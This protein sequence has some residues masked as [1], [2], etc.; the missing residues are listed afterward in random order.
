MRFGF[1]CFGL[2]KVPRVALGIASM[3]ASMVSAVQ[4]GVVNLGSF[5]GEFVTVGDP[6]NRAELTNGFGAVSETF[7]IM[8]FEFTNQQYV[9]FLNSV[10]PNGNQTNGIYNASMGSDARGGISFDSG[11]ATG[12]KYAVRL[13]MHHKPVNYVSW[14]DAARVANWLHNGATS[15]SSMETGAYTL[16]NA[17]TGNAVPVNI[18][19]RF[20][21][22]SENQWYKAAYYKGGS[23]N[24]GYWP[25]ATQSLVAPFAVT[26]NTTG[27]GSAGILDNFAN[28]NDAA[29]WNGQNGNVT[30]VGTNGRPSAYGAFDMIGNVREWNDLNSSG[31]SSRGIRGGG[32][33]S[34]AAGLLSSTRDTFNPSFEFNVFGFRVASLPSSTPPAVPEPSMMVIGTLFGLGGLLAKRRMKK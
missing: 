25:Y 2:F 15:A 34:S 4:A 10:D 7:D 17:T 6:G 8:K 29:D 5:S 9:Q 32:W 1:Y 3:L 24:A 30:T 31:S 28:Y 19:A 20:F 21:I 13:N 16:N 12:S 11:A 22:P 23:T 18:G 27:D 14:F 26:A 33:G